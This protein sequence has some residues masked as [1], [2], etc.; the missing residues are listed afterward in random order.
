MSPIL[1]KYFLCIVCP[2]C[3]HNAA[4]DKLEDVEGNSMLEIVDQDW[5]ELNWEGSLELVCPCCDQKFTTGLIHLHRSEEFY[6][7]ELMAEVHE[8]IERG[9]KEGFYEQPDA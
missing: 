4:D 5:D 6:T 1:N 9:K 3:L 8:M 2:V 7:P